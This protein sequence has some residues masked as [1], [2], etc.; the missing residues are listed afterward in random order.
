M[1]PKNEQR[2]RF[3]KS[4]KLCH[5]GEIIYGQRQAIIFVKSSSMPW[6]I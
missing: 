1:A 2:S 5:E 3:L 4:G 6:P